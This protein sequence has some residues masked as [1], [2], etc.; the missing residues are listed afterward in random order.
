MEYHL[1]LSG[2][3]GV[4]IYSFLLD[5][6]EERFHVLLICSHKYIYIYIFFQLFILYWS[7]VDLQCCVRF[8]CTT[9]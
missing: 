8:S 9:K 4:Y 7:I 3:D 1:L 5:C 2:T 6:E